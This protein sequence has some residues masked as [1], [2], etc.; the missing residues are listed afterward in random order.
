MKKIYLSI[1][2]AVSMSFAGLKVVGPY[3]VDVNYQ[4]ASFKITNKGGSKV[5]G[6]KVTAYIT[7]CGYSKGLTIPEDLLQLHGGKITSTTRLSASL[8]KVNI[9]FSK[10]TIPANGSFPSNG[11]YLE[12]TLR[13][14]A[15]GAFCSART[16]ISNSSQPKGD[17][18]Q[19]NIVVKDLSGKT[20]WGKAV[21]DDG[22]KR[23]GVLH[24]GIPKSNSCGTNL[25]K[26]DVIILDTENG[27]ANTHVSSG[28]SNPPG[29][30]IESKSLIKFSFCSQDSTPPAAFDYIVL[31]KDKYCP[32]GTYEFGRYHDAEDNNNKN[33]FVGDIWPSV[34]DRNA[35]LYFCFVPK[36]NDYKKV[37]PYVKEYGVFAN[38]NWTNVLTSE[39][40]VDDED[41]DNEN[42]WIG[43]DKL[44]KDI[45]KRIKKIMKDDDKKKNTIYHV[46][47][48]NGIPLS[49]S[50]A[51]VAESPISAGQPL[52]AAAPL[53]PAI[54]GL[55]RS[56]VAVELKSEGKVKVSIVNVNGSV[57]ANIAQES[58][59]PGIHQIKWNSGMVPSGRY[60]VKIEQNGMVNAK[61]VILK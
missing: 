44:S 49:K 19:P 27:G 36:S 6:F 10:Q 59:Q 31:K 34:I 48:W 38:P 7:A 56:A 46:A 50:A 23:V 13:N 43:L 37:Y 52:V 35:T 45:Q 2:L 41:D 55:D 47:M 11:S 39:V 42:K 58:L 53:A 25:D 15:G 28:Y 22:N 51:D 54:K 9:D 12:M 30:E 29:I 1:L 40:F 3:L 4:K 16:T 24:N 61:N 20:L 14:Y 26:E 60:I 18:D 5:S 21:K 8:Y 17:D 32:P 33:S 57:I